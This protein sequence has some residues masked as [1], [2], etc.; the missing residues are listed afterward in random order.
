MLRKI[1]IAK[2]VKNS[3]RK[4]VLI[5]LA[6]LLIR[7]LGLVYVSDFNN[8]DTEEFGVIANY[9]ISGKGYS[10]HSIND[11]PLPSAYMPPGYPLLLAGV[12]YIFGVGF[13]SFVIIEILQAFI[14]AVICMLLYVIAHKKFSEK[15]AFYSALVLSFYPTFVYLSSQFSASNLYIFLNLV[16]VLLLFRGEESNNIITFLFAGIVLGMLIL[17]RAQVLAYLPFIG[18]W[19]YF[20][21]SKNRLKNISAFVLATLLVLTPWTLR[22]YHVFGRFVPL[23]T[24]GGYNLCRGHNEKAIETTQPFRPPKE[25]N[26]KIAKLP[27]T[28][29]YEVRRD[30]I[31]RDEAL[32][33]IRENPIES[34][35]LLPLKKFLDYWIYYLD[36]YPGAKSFLY[37]FPWTLMLPFFIIGIVKTVNQFQKYSLFYLYFLLST[38]IIMIFFVLPRYRMFITPFVIPFSVHGALEL[39]KKAKS[40]WFPKFKSPDRN[41][42]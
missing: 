23:T 20:R 32:T 28:K 42:C 27:Y 29:D 9:L 16:L 34:F 19:I 31:Y 38:I 11:S 30:N 12:C 10:Y 22:N 40:L 3:N 21:T 2:L 8:P 1:D 36:D 33:F 4:L 7:L 35:L 17:S 24:G 14:G 5:F 15:V 41:N 6:A 18:I 37:W 39:W 13:K 26:E 25:L